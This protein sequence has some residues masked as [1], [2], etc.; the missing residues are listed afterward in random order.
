MI[1]LNKG[2]AKLKEDYRYLKT[3]HTDLTLKIQSLTAG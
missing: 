1:E 2:F 3:S